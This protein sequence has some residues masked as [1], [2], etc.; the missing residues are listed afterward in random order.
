YGGEGEENG[1]LSEW[2]LP[3][4]D[5][6]LHLVDHVLTGGERFAAVGGDDLDP[7]GGFIHAHH[8]DAVNKAHGFDRPFSFH[9]AENNLKLAAG[10]F[11]EGLIFY[12][13]N[14]LPLLAGAH[15]TRKVNGSAHAGGHDT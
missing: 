15:D 2:S 4:G 12:G 9:L 8:S 3:D 1:Y 5:E 14:C 11:F 6:A 7:K 10:H 13:R